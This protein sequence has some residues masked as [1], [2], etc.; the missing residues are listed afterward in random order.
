MLT[1]SF[2]ITSNLIQKFINNPRLAVFMLLVIS[3]TLVI[4][5]RLFN[6]YISQKN[7]FLQYC[8]KQPNILQ[9]LPKYISRQNTKH[10]A[11]Q[12]YRLNAIFLSYIFYIILL[13]KNVLQ[14]CM[15]I[16]YGV[17]IIISNIMVVVVEE[18]I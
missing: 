5:A 14:M 11:K 1:P 12:L 7:L 16:N 6:K 3:A 2:E 10:E 13:W 15:K 4:S 8:L 17:I 18:V 9:F